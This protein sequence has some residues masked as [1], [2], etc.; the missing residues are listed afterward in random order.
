MFHLHECLVGYLKV[1]WE[2]EL[3]SFHGLSSTLQDILNHWPPHTAKYH[4]EQRCNHIFKN[5]SRCGTFL[6]RMTKKRRRQVVSV[7]KSEER[8]KKWVRVVRKDKIIV[9]FLCS[10]IVGN[11]QRFLWRKPYDF[12][13][14]LSLLCIAWIIKVQGWR[15]LQIN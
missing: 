10:T 6:L 5:A 12:K 2:A 4:I 3:Y 7:Q 11:C 15:D 14:S 9:L 1:M 8:D 13:I